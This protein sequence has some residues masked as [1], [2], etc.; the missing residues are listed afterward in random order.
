MEKITLV[1][2]VETSSQA[3]S[4][5]INI[6]GN[7]VRIAI[8]HGQQVLFCQ[9]VSAHKQ[10][11]AI[12]TDHLENITL[13]ALECLLADPETVEWCICERVALRGG[14]NSDG[15]LFVTS[16]TTARNHLPIHLRMG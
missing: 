5:E 12:T 13:K 14:T 8:T 10:I 7:V 4:S 1:N 15:C 2:A 11:T 3:S 9:V 6:D 16:Q